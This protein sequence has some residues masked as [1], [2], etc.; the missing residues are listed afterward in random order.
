MNNTWFLNLNILHTTDTQRKL[1]ISTSDRRNTSFISR[2]HKKH[3]I[4]V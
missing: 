2:N 1:L 3:E 4:L